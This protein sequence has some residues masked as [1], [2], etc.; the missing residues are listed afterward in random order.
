MLSRYEK[1]LL[2]V[3][4]P[5]QS[6]LEH[7]NWCRWSNSIASPSLISESFCRQTP[8]PSNPRLRILD[9]IVFERPT[10]SRQFIHREP[11]HPCLW[12]G[13][14]MASKASPKDDNGRCFD[15]SLCSYLPKLRR[16]L[17]FVYLTVALLASPFGINSKQIR[18]SSPR[19]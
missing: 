14:Q 19:T 6:R 17:A 12:G 15:Q 8:I 10:Q 1:P 5:A 11:Q 7:R 9:D 2:P 13:G 18:R 4:P 16:H 3:N